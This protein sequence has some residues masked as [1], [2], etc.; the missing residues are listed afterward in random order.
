MEKHAKNNNVI[1]FFNFFRVLISQNQLFNDIF[2]ITKFICLIGLMKMKIIYHNF[3]FN[4]YFIDHFTVF[5]YIF[6]I[7]YHNFIPL[8]IILLHVIIITFIYF[9]IVFY[10]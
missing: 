9:L 1:K 6:I 7:I 2:I 5:V 4:L 10:L 3:I 8:I